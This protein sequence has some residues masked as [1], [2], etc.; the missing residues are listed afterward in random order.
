MR[1]VSA[2]N[3]TA[4]PTLISRRQAS[5]VY[6]A[7]AAHG[8]L[9]VLVNDEHTNFRIATADL[10]TPG[11]WE[12]IIPGSDE[13]YLRRLTSFQDHLV[14]EERLNGLDQVRLYSYSGEEQRISF[15]EASYTASLD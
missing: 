7:D 2:S 1:F 15:P 14:I 13:V 10:A 5:R 12:T 8:K 11:V 3:P 4:A 9:W 6:S